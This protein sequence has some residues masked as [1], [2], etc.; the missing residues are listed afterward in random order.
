MIGPIRESGVP[1]LSLMATMLGAPPIQLPDSAARPIQVSGGRNRPS[2]AR[3]TGPPTMIPSE[4]A[5][6]MINALLPRRT[7][8][9]RSTVTINSTRLTGSR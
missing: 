6:I 3:A 1:T 8:A 4:P 2:R 9:R 5:S 7:T